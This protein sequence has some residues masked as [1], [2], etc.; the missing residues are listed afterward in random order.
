M[1]MAK[2]KQSQSINPAQSQ[3][4]N[5]QYQKGQ[6]LIE[7][8]SALAI[9]SIVIVAVTTAVT[10]S[11]SNSE[12]NQNQ[13][14]AT[15]YAQQGT[16]IVTQIRDQSYASFAGYTGP[17]YCLAQNQSTLGVA[18]STNC[19]STN[20]TTANDNFIRSVQIQ[21]GGCAANVAQITVKVSFTNSKCQAGT[22][23]HGAT[24]VSCLSTKNP[25]LAP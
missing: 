21:Q 13:T 19:S 3:Y 8:L 12:F 14:L 22:Y 4:N 20:I 16:E 7:T 17:Y 2:Q 18:Q 1:D 24:D 9:L 11:L 15:K 23:C 6:T 10:T 5:M 25:V